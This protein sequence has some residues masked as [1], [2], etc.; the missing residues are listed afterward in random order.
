MAT[1]IG[2]NVTTGAKLSQE[3]IPASVLSLLQQPI[4]WL[5][6]ARKPKR[7]SR[8]ISLIICGPGVS[9]LFLI[10]SLFLTAFASYED[11]HASL[12]ASGAHSYFQV[13]LSSTTRWSSREMRVSSGG[14][15]RKLWGLLV[16]CLILCFR[17][18][19]WVKLIILTWSSC[20][21]T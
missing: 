12:S 1:F 5:G 16:P 8:E 18:S 14:Q 15:A 11:A 7:Q 13:L 20:L 2:S 17:G 6:W 10:C 9:C 4:R 3:I 21:G 19:P